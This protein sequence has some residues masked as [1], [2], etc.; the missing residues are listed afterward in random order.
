VKKVLTFAITLLVFA[1]VATFT[2][3][4][5]APL[6]FK[7]NVGDKD[8]CLPANPYQGYQVYTFPI[9]HNDLL[10]VVGA[11]TDL[12][13]VNSAKAKGFQVA[14]S[15]GGTDLSQI[16]TVEV[17]MKLA[18]NTTSLGDQI[19]YSTAFGTGIS[20]VTLSLNGTDVK[21]ALSNDM[22]M[23]VKVLNV[24]SGNTPICMKLTQGYI[25]MEV[26]Q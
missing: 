15:S 2:S 8:L 1:G 6:V 20:N 9:N 19:A 4:T 22:V 10:A 11:T 16:A 5:K 12:S 3:C 13:K 23:T 18:T 24:T 25:E 7:Y 14:L 17:Y 21:Q 26:K